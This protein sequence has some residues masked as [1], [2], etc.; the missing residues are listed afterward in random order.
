MTAGETDSPLSLG[1]WVALMGTDLSEAA[2]QA[3]QPVRV[4]DG[5][6]TLLSGMVNKQI[7]AG[8]RI[9]VCLREGRIVLSEVPEGPEVQET[10]WWDDG[11]HL[12]IELPEAVRAVLPEGEQVPCLLVERG[13]DL[14]LMPVRVEEHAPDVLG[15]RIID[16]VREADEGQ[17][18][19]IVRHSA[20]Q[21]HEAPLRRGRR[22]PRR[23]DRGNKVD[24]F[25]AT[26]DDTTLFRPKK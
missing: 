20:R 17:P 22:S 24:I 15:P 9:G 21:R 2:C 26:L 7:A 11:K 4:E 3:L 23:G 18:P 14:E 12:E 10:G 25:A 19:G 13:N 6:L 8:T 5:K 1:T 16:E